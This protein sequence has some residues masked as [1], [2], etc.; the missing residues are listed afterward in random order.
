MLLKTQ[1]KFG[2]IR[3][4]RSDFSID[5][6]AKTKK[7]Q[8]QDRKIRSLK[9]HVAKIDKFFELAHVDTLLS[10]APTTTGV[11]TLLNGIAVG[12]TDILRDGNDMNATSIQWKYRVVGDVD[13]LNGF[14]IRHMIFW[15]Q[16]ANGAAPGLTDVLDTAVVTSAVIAPYNRNN[17]KRFKIIEDKLFS[18][19]PVVNNAAV[20]GSGRMSSH[21]KRQLSRLVKYIGTGATIASIGTNSLF[22]LI[23]ADANTD[24]P[25]FQAG[26]RYYAKDA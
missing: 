8:A 22:S 19:N 3:H 9:K 24:A 25:V 2:N 21:G 13:S 4:G 5:P 20:A 7:D 23:L 16:Q 10:S 6:P 1:G 15:D 18:Y 17:Q 14:N 11:F 26:Y 12:D